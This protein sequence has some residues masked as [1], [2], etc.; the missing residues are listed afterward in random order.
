MPRLPAREAAPHT[1]EWEAAGIVDRLIWKQA[2]ATGLL[3]FE[4]P[5]EF[6]GAGVKDFRYNAILGEEIVAT[7]SVG[8]GFTLHNDI[9]APYL[10]APLQ[11]RAEGAL[12]ARA[13]SPARSSPRSR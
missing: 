1:A 2:G 11:R 7:G 4:V 10:L 6:G 5:E 3:G 12:A 8:V 9:V 13:S